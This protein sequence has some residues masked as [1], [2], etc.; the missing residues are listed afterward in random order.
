MS[1]RPNEEH[2]FS[3]EG[4]ATP[5]SQHVHFIAAIAMTA[6]NILFQLSRIVFAPLGQSPIA[7]FCSRKIPL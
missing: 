6:R 4:V 7:K 2:S 5:L 1:S 3:D